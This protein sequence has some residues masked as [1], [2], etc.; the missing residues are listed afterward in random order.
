MRSF[1]VCLF[2]TACV[3]L[4]AQSTK[5]P[6]DYYV[7]KAVTNSPLQMDEHNQS[8]ILESERQYLKNVCIHAQTLLTGSYLFVPI[9]TNENGS[10]SFKW[11]AQSADDYYGYDLGVSNGNLQCGV[12][13]TK[14]LLGRSVY[15]A[16]ESQI[17][18]QQD[19]LKNNIRLSRHD[20]ER[21]VIDQ[22]ILCM[23][24]QNQL[25]YAD[26]I[27]RLLAI[28]ESLITRLAYAG[29]AKQ[30][31]IQ[32]IRIEQ[33][34]NKEMMASCRQS[35]R[36]HL[37]ELNALCCIKDTADV[38]VENI[39]IR[40]NVRMEASGFLTKYKLDSVHA[41]TLQRAYETKYKPQLNLFTNFGLQTTNYGSMYKHFGASAGLTFSMLLS[42]GRLK[43][44]R[45]RET[46]AALSSISIYRDNLVAQNDIRLSQCT[47][48]VNDDDV[49]LGM[50]DA[51]ITEYTRLLDICR[52]EMKMGQMSVFD[53]ITTLK[54]I[55]SVRR[56]KMTLEANRQ[57]AVNAYNYYNW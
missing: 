10:T 55:I 54:N 52:K 30:S 1:F 46:D 18:V 29:Q 7:S 17:G 39:A 38:A 11:N 49:R 19:I 16:A 31:D 22:Y 51:Q 6:L 53:Y 32:L 37:M 25:A 44:I 57:L 3:S 43:K 14:P 36:S 26:S 56:Q 24:D 35:Y 28:Q 34:A 20:I 42:D 5:R 12:T 8:A 27:S 40:K 50:L 15:Q 45:Q 33:S 41:V 9:V 47:A 23:L 21:N 13:W 48:A 2:V 4:T